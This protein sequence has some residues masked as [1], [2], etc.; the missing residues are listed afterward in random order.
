MPLT[1]ANTRLAATLLARDMTQQELVD[2]SGISRVT[3]N[4]IYHGRSASLDTWV[5]LAN[6]LNVAIA[7]IAPPDVA[8]LIA[9]VT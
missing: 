5:R 7:E 2:C 6:A 4:N 1:R 9:A 8:A 3:I